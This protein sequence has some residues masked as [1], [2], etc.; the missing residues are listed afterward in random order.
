M[1]TRDYEKIL[2]AEHNNKQVCVHKRYPLT[3]RSLLVPATDM[4]PE[5][6]IEM[7][8]LDDQSKESLYM[9]FVAAYNYVFF[10]KFAPATATG[11]YSSCVHNFIKW[12]NQHEIKNKYEVL[13]EYES[14]RFDLLDNHGGASALANIKTLFTHAI[15]YSTEL[16]AEISSDQFKYLQDLRKTKISP[17][18]KKTHKSIASYF[19]GLDWLRREDVGIGNELYT[20]FASA[21]LSINSL[22][23]T[24]STIIIELYSYKKDL[25]VFLRN[26]KIES[27][28]SLFP[29]SSSTK[30]KCIFIG[31]FVSQIITAY[32]RNGKNDKKL[33]SAINI[34]ILS[35]LK[36][37]NGY[38]YF[39]GLLGDEKRFNDKYP[40]GE[41]SDDHCVKYFTSDSSGCLFS[42]EIMKSLIKDNTQPICNIESNM[43]A[44]LMAALT[45]QPY[46]IPKLTN[47]DF[48]KIIIGQRVTHIE[49]EY[50]KGR[51][52]LFSTTRSVSANNLE[53]KAILIFLSRSGDETFVRSIDP[54]RISNGFRSH[55]GC[56]ASIIESSPIAEVIHK[57]HGKSDLPPLIPKAIVKLIQHGV[58]PSVVSIPYTLS[59]EERKKLSNASDT[60]CQYSIFGLQA[61]K[62][63]AVHAFSDPYTLDYLINHN[64]HTNKTEKKNYLSLNG[65]N[66][67]YLNSC[68]RITREVMFDLINN[69]LNLRFDGLNK[70]ERTE[71]V[72]K[73]NSE[74]TVVT[75][76][77]EYRKEE[78]LS[79]LK[80]VSG[81]SK[82]DFNEVGVLALDNSQLTSFELIYVLDNP[83]T[84]WKMMNYIHEFKKHYRKLLISNP[85]FFY[86]TA[87]PTAEWTEAALSRLSKDSQKK[88]LELFKLM[89][90]HGVEIS[91]FHSI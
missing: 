11:M 2:Q 62:N 36:S 69:V 68:G 89:L 44:W 43:F 83:T 38:L 78:M 48:R 87:M 17:N 34:I 90:S 76:H 72:E 61:I 56:F 29:K 73:F 33:E 88:G 35:N 25:S 60:H 64:S 53:G 84:A 21:K 3:A 7:T 19:G 26:N 39:V 1:D 23:I 28:S 24:A 30:H 85:K 52:N 82:G 5:R 75:E 74:F 32:H 37:N 9:L 54:F 42:L 18:I 79:R 91:V 6:Y 8:D 55:S 86:K 71:E 57:N 80:V 40:D 67:E 63:S 27:L 66:E 51:S 46:D 58:N 20:L 45:V 31:K 10:D 14:Y 65:D 41:I 59:F 47:K 22:I 81:Q 4:S 15:E 49:C 77:I 70:K 12:L 50:F 16:E 13:K